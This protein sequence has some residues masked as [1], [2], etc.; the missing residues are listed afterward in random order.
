MY[1]V[2]PPWMSDKMWELQQHLESANPLTSNV[3]GEDI[4]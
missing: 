2:Q 3:E 4:V 1:Q